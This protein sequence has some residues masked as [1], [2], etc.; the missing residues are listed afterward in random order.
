[1]R[2]AI[3]AEYDNNIKLTTKS[4]LYTEMLNGK[5]E[6][7]ITTTQQKQ[8]NLTSGV[9]EHSQLDTD[10]HWTGG[11]KHTQTAILIVLIIYRFKVNIG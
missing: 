4:R 1:M 11:R 3:T 7:L 10:T 6:T 9:H 2:F 8:R 5:T